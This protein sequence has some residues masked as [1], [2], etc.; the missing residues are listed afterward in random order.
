[1]TTIAAIGPDDWRAWRTIRLRALLEAP[2]AFGTTYAKAAGPSDHENYWRGYFVTNG[3]NYVADR[4]GD[5]IGIVRVV[6]PSQGGVAEL[7]SLWVAP[8]ARGLGVGAALVER[9][10]DWLQRSAPGESLHLNVRR[11][12][13]AARRLYERLGFAVIGPA[14]DDPDEDVMAKHL[15]AV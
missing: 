3:Q 6:G 11:H 4:G 10:W 12:N 5:V 14:A 7:M 15:P 2:E 8:E 1:M 13:R 9:C